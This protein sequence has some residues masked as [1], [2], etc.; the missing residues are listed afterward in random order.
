MLGRPAHGD[1]ERRA[2]SI[3]IGE[4]GF[5]AF[6]DALLDSPEYMNCFGYDLVPSS[7]PALSRGPRRNPDLPTIPALR[8]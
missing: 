6:V 4:K 7:G 3:V 8:N 5:T 2:W 1:A